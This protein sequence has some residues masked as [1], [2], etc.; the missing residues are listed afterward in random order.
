MK[1]AAALATATAIVLAPPWR[2]RARAADATMLHLAAPPTDASAQYYYADVQGFFKKAGFGFD[3]AHLAN[4]EAV[5]A[6][7]IGGSIDIGVSQA[8]SLIAAYSHGIPLTIIAGSAIN[9]ARTTPGSSGAFFVPKNSTATSGKDLIGKTIGVQGLRGYAQ[10]GT[11]AWL[12]KT[13]G[14]SSSVHFVELTSSVMGR[15]LADNRIDG[16]FIP[17][18]N[19]ADVAKVAKK[20]ATPMDAIAPVFFAGAHFTT[21]AWAKAHV[22]VVRRFESLMYETAAWANKNHDATADILAN[23]AHIDPSVVHAAVRADYATRRDPALLQP[24][25]ALA[26]KYTGITAFPAEDLF[27]KG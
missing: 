24:L 7:V 12:D 15:A 20:I 4:G 2:G 5:T 9:S 14:D 11:Q 25:I 8:I 27:F 16:A 23:A 22:D 26:A 10:Y 18:P 6:A 21:L 19:V 13:G 17:E 3:I 1:R